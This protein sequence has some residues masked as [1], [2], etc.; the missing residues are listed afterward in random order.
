M[1]ARASVILTKEN[2]A[3]SPCLCQ[4]WGGN[5]F[6]ENV[7]EFILKLYEA[8]HSKDNMQPENRLEPSRVF[9]KLVKEFGEGGYVECSRDMVDDSDYGC[10]Y[11]EL[12]DKKPN[13]SI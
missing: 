10:L 6:H 1:G 7:R 4:H 9:I 5:E 3:D 8:D 13:F 11:V 2:H 12:E